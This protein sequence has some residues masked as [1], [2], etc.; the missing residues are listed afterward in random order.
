MRKLGHGHSLMFFAPLGIDQHIRSLANKGHRDNIDIV[1]VLHWT[2]RETCDEIQQRA[3]QWAQQGTDHI[4]RYVAWSRLC[5]RQMGLKVLLDKWLQPEAKRLE[6][7]YGPHK[8]MPSLRV[9]PA[10]RQRCEDLGTLS[11]RNLGMD[12]EQEREIIREAER[13]RQVERPE[14]VQ[15]V[16]HSIHPD[17]VLFVKTGIIH[18]NSRAFRPAFES[19]DVMSTAS[20]EAHIWSRSVRVTMDFEK[21]VDSPEK[22]DDFLRPVQWI[23]SRQTSRMDPILVILS[24]HEANHLM[25]DIRT[26]DHVRLH[27]YTPRVTKSMK[28]CDDPPLYSIP[29]LPTG[30][31]VP[32]PLMDQL[33]MFSGQL[34]FKD[35]ETYIRL[36]RFLRVYERGPE[37]EEGNKARGSWL[38]KLWSPPRR[39]QLNTQTCQSPQLWSLK[40]LIGFRRKGVCFTQTHMGKL[41]DGRQLSES[42]FDGCADVRLIVLPFPP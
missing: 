24:P 5:E 33:N 4:S 37:G 16:A 18:A 39:L 3:P 14:R 15:P 28:P 6:D 40:T 36:C 11:F 20:N 22:M 41:L 38:I 17:V 42:D 27:V 1:D 9:A 2:I 34:Y 10:I 13:E 23:V 29:M 8:T 21:T 26:S 35:Y 12:E 30:G 31:T 25:S 7:L 19:L 32:S